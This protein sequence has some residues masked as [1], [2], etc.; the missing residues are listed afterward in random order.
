MTVQFS[1][2]GKLADGTPVTAATLTNRNGA[3]LTVLDYGATVQSL[4]IPNREGSLV[5]VVLG[6]DSIEEYVRHGEFLGATI[7]RVG[8]RI[9]GGEFSLNGT[10]YQLARND[11][12]NHLHGGIEGFDRRLWRMAAQGGT[13]L[14]WRTSPDGEEGYPGTLQ[15]RVCFSL[16]DENALRIVYDADTDQD[17]LV[18]LTNH[19]Y[20]NLNGE[21]S[22]LEHQLQLFAERFCENGK[23][24]L[25]TGK[26]LP[27]ENTPFD[28][29]Q[30]KTI[31]AEIGA[32][33]EQLVSAGGY[34]HNYVL[35]GKKAAVLYSP[36]SGI[37]MTVET[38]MPGMQLYTGN[39]LP[40]CPGKNGTVICRQGAAC[41]E[42]QLFP[43]GMNCYGFP[44]PVLR[45]G[46]HLHSETDYIFRLRS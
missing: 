3:S 15:V 9:A 38:D 29:R 16:T 17:T 44:S 12:E 14:C 37:E 22:V 31:G 32:D 13:L 1:T 43:N 30:E 18:N 40:E 41:F 19:S 5:D 21:G 2:F 35:C 20:F 42:T 10:R 4:R 25:P 8:N 24:C 45:A 23:G 46:T 26:L 28:F 36:D 7:G 34:D 11:G 6:Y 33:D 39:F 27:V